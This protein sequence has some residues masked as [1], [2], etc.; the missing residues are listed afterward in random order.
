MNAK[1]RTY[2]QFWPIYVGVHTKRATRVIHF[3]GT[4]AAIVCLLL[5]LL[6]LNAWWLLAVP[7]AGY[8]G[9][10]FSHAFVERNK[11]A[12]FTHPLWSLIA[13]FHMYWL[14]WQGRMD[15]EVAR[16][17]GGDEVP[18]RDRAGEADRVREHQDPARNHTR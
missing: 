11:P 1:P 7:I 15:A 6:T 9:A 4:S 12:T 16:I 14:I 5:A 2:R 10:W 3:A 17:L 18:Q 13:D 8:G